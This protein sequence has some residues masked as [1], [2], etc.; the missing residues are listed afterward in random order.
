MYRLSCHAHAAIAR[1][2]EVLGC[3][4]FMVGAQR[5]RT[6]TKAFY[7]AAREYMLHNDLRGACSA[8]A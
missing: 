4:Q 2:T 5:I 7:E 3:T 1:W 8:T 6:R